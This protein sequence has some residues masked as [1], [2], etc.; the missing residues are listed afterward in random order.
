MAGL[1]QFCIFL[2]ILIATRGVACV[3][4]DGECEKPVYDRCQQDVVKLWSDETSCYRDKLFIDCLRIAGLHC[5]ETME[6][7]IREKV[8]EV[9]A[10]CEKDGD[11]VS[12]YG[13]H[14]YF[15]QDQATD[16]TG[17]LSPGAIAGIV[18][19]SIVL[20]AIIVLIVLY[21]IYYRSSF[22]NRR[23]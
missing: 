17:K 15:K 7:K 21:V 6:A 5:G 3:D 18:I 9:E 16:T 12:D 23:S 13:G 2:I 20:L 22:L 8:V 19:G 4:F 10:E 11:H 1:S 14:D